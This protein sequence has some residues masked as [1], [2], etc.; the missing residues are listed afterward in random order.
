MEFNINAC[1]NKFIQSKKKY[2][3]VCLSTEDHDFIRAH[4]LSPTLIVRNVLN[5]LKK[6]LIEDSKQE[7]GNRETD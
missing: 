3:N 2:M 6:E 4:D 5:N 7:D 1:K